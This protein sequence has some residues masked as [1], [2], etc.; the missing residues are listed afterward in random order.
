MQSIFDAL[1]AE[2]AD[3]EALPKT[4]GAAKKNYVLAALEVSGMTTPD[5]HAEVSMLIEMV[6]F[7][8]RRPEAL[9]IFRDAQAGCTGFCRQS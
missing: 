9:K 7:L 1:I 3:A 5:N 4:A 2:M 6:L 8:A